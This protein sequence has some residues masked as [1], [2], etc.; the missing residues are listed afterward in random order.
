MLKT[1]GL[2]KL[3]VLPDHVYEMPFTEWW[4]LYGALVLFFAAG[5]SVKHVT[6]VR[7]QRG[8]GAIVPLYGLVPFVVTWTLVP[9]YLYLQP[10]ILREH[11]VPFT[12][13]VGLV[14]AYSVGQIIV[15]HLVKGEFP[16]SNIL[17]WPL[18]LAVLDSLCPVLGLWPSVLGYG[19][20]G[21]VSFVYLCLGLS[22]GVYGSFV[23]SL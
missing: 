9:S 20:V 22:V 19:G 10:V 2:P 7:R 6:S 8:Q 14:N 5:S 3:P 18:A 13:F 15:A 21:Q 17:I 12:L 1:L 23:V 4:I 16:C 11:L